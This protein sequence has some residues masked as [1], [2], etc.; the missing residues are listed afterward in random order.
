M[1]IEKYVSNDFCSTLIDSINIFDRRLSGVILIIS[2]IS[3]NPYHAGYFYVLHSSPIFS[4]ETSQISFEQPHHMISVE[5]M[6]IET[7]S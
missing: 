7:P 6:K 2:Y 1:A 5:N 3:I 4:T